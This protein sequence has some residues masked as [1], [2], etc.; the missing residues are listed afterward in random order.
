ME[1]QPWE[2]PARATT[3]SPGMKGADASGIVIDPG[4]HADARRWPYGMWIPTPDVGDRNVLVPGTNGLSDGS[5]TALSSR[6]ARGID[7]GVG[8]FLQ[9]LWPPPKLVRKN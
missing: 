6:L 7:Q 8:S 4:E 5:S 1:V 2:P 9:W 3:K